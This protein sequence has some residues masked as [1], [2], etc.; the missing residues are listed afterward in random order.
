RLLKMLTMA[1]N[2]IRM[3]KSIPDISF[4]D[5]RKTTQEILP[6]EKPTPSKEDQYRLY[7]AH[8]LE[9]GQLY[10]G[11]KTLVDKIKGYDTVVIDGYIGVFWDYFRE[12]LD[13]ELALAGQN[14]NWLDISKALKSPNKI[15]DII[16]PFLGGDDPIF[17]S[18]FTG[19]LKDFF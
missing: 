6:S 19:G 14:V 15:D 17:G 9:N 18:R 12:R 8:E 1:N 11:Y 13:H 4:S 3:K 16:A 5:W 10:K 2:L 7:P